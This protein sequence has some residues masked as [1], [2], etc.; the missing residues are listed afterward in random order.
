MKPHLKLPSEIPHKKTVVITDRMWNNRFIHVMRY[1]NTH[2]TAQH[3]KVPRK[4]Y[5]MLFFF[6][7]CLI[8]IVYSQQTRLESKR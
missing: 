4:R 5:L 6:F 2:K 7:L 8:F 3:L 1:T